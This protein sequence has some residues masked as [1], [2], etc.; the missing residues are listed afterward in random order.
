MAVGENVRRLPE[1]VGD[2]EAVFLGDRHVDARHQR[3]MVGHVA[4]VAVTEIGADVFRPLIGLGKQDFAGHVRIEGGPD[5]LDDFVGFRE[6]LVVGPLAFAQIR[7]GVQ[8]EAVDAEIG[9]PPHDLNHGGKH[10]RIVVIEIRL[11]RKETM[12]VIGSCNRIPRPI[13]FFGIIEDDAR[14]R[15]GLVGIAPHIPFARI[16]SRLA[17][18]RAL[19]PRMLIGTVIDDQLGNHA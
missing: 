15:V 2:G 9:P 16:R 13:R 11:M 6:I 3:K 4:L 5:L 10:A 14:S 12:P 19:K 17:A 18:A 8:P 1:N 7:D